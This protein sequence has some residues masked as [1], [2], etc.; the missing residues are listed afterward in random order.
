MA[1][2]GQ[3]SCPERSRRAC[4]PDF[5]CR[6]VRTTPSRRVLTYRTSTPS[7]TSGLCCKAQDC[8]VLTCRR[9][10]KING[11]YC[12][13]RGVL[14]QSRLYHIGQSAQ[15]LLTGSVSSLSDISPRRRLGCFRH[16]FLQ[17]FVSCMSRG[18]GSETGRIGRSCFFYFTIWREP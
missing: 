14:R 13:C 8:R 9:F 16:I 11:E 7:C 4:T 6:S 1:L 2:V 5:Y 18:D 17:T 3:E 12:R 15:V 10:R